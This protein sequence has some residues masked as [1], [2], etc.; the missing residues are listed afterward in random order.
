[1]LHIEEDVALSA[2]NGRLALAG[3]QGRAAPLT[4]VHALRVSSGLSRPRAPHF[5]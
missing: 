4:G 2:M 1:M 3:E 5:L